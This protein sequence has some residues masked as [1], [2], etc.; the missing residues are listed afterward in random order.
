M[1]DW[2][3]ITDGQ[4][5]I[6]VSVLTCKGDGD[7]RYLATDALNFGSAERYSKPD[8]LYWDSGSDYDEIT[9]WAVLPNMPA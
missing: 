6:G 2:I 3:K 4:P 1:I 7:F 8:L 9:H 5:P